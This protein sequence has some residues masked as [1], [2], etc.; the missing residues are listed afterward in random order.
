MN[1][2]P[3]AQLLDA[4]AHD[5]MGADAGNIATI[6]PMLDRLAGLRTLATEQALTRLRDAAGELERITQQI[7]MD[8]GNAA[9]AAQT[10]L[11]ESLAAIQQAMESDELAQLPGL[12]PAIEARLRQPD[13]GATFLQ[14]FDSLL[15][16]LWGHLRDLQQSPAEQAT[17]RALVASLA[18]LA[19]HSAVAAPA[20]AAAC[21]QVATRDKTDGQALDATVLENILRW[22]DGQYERLAAGQD[23]P[24]MPEAAA[25]A[26]A[27]A[28]LDTAPETTALPAPETLV[29]E[30]DASVATPPAPPAP[31]AATSTTAAPG[32]AALTGDLDL[33]QDFVA[34]SREHLELASAQL[35]ALEAE[36]GHTEALNCVFRAFHTIKGISGF[37][38][39][40][41]IER[42]S[43]T[44]ENLLDRVRTSA[45]PLTAEVLDVA[46]S[47]LDMLMRMIDRVRDA[48]QGDGWLPIE[49]GLPALLSAIVA[50]DQQAETAPA[51]APR[52]SEPA[53]AAPDMGG[54]G[55]DAAETERMH[56]EDT[57]AQAA[58]APG[59]QR[60]AGHGG[61]PRETIRV[62]YHRLEAMVDTIGELVIAEAAIS[63]DPAVEAV[64]NGLLSKKLHN[65]KQVSRKLQEFG[66]AV[67]MVPIAGTF[68]KLAR[69]VRDLSRK[70]GKTVLL[71]VDGEE[72]EIDRAFV[73]NIG[74]PLIHMVRNAVDHGIEPANVRSAAGKPT[75]G[76]IHLRAFHEG[77]N[78]HV[79][80]E[81]DGKGL[82]KAAILA[83]AVE[84]GLIA[85]G[86]PLSEQETFNLIF[87]PG[88]S[89]AA[90]VTEVSGRGV[91]MDVVRRNI[92]N[93]RGT[94]HIKSTP[95]QGTTFR[96]TLPL[97][98]ALID[99]MV[100]RVGSARFILPVLSV[101][102]SLRPTAKMLQ[103]VMGR[104]EL[105]NMRHGQLPLYRMSR[106]FDIPGAEQEP[107]RALA[108]VVE[109]NGTR[110]ALLV[111]ELLGLQQTVVKSLG[112][113]SDQAEGISGGAIMADG[114]V[115]LILDVPAL[116]DI[117]W[118][119]PAAGASVMPTT[120][121]KQDPTTM[122]AINQ[123]PQL[124][125]FRHEH[126]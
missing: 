40:P 99:G 35:L 122:V 41:E 108:V 123:H 27:H 53:A 71:H 81:D 86:T 31:P 43:H 80:I 118:R 101:V 117:A 16:D 85:E 51:V 55:D 26:I 121:P 60:S 45:I 1:T 73:D 88:F 112:P 91:G 11:S 19:E 93:L 75:S 92:Q 58:G 72:T 44:T 107:T 39:L 124:E 13:E 38:Q 47:A 30:T 65:L 18:A 106:L 76:T 5:V 98:M 111:D 89:T 2:E 95:G 115:G 36:P 59:S 52:P 48:M 54:K 113:L 74:D 12:P 46:F 79:E 70:S 56:A 22:I 61:E 125:S 83:K 90:A 67:R 6:A 116:I 66:T 49:P 32:G 7:I 33:L 102:E 77:G 103:S 24:A 119:A 9:E 64:R 34:E 23:E 114:S 110:W 8:E 20:V 104:G 50:A 42:L 97:T 29:A 68:Q 63:Q 28:S 15:H 25:P 126:A 4:L 21:R 109:R 17:P 3:I 78:I 14:R 84:R 10:L 62:D 94:V 100:V 120:P 82:D 69:L 87:E 37:L 57:D 105:L 96:M